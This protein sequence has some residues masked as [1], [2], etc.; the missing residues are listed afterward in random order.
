MVGSTDGND[1]HDDLMIPLS[2][3]HGEKATIAAMCDMLSA[4]CGV[5]SL[6][7]LVLTVLLFSGGAIEK[8]KQR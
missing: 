2:M 5:L 4:G 8:Q 3:E 7:V 1:I 6:L